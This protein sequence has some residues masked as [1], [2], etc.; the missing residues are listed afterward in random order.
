M[1]IPPTPRAACPA[2]RCRQS[3]PEGRRRVAGGQPS[4]APGTRFTDQ[5]RPGGAVD[6]NSRAQLRWLFE[7]N[8]ELRYSGR[9]NGAGTVLPHEREEV[10][11]LIESL[12]A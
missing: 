2:G 12:R 5:P 11:G 4:A 6:E 9:P 7:R 1:S 3:A 10:L 8:D